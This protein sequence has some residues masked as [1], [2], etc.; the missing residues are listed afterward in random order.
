MKL[1]NNLQFIKKTTSDE[2]YNF[3][4]E[5]NKNNLVRRTLHKPKTIPKYNYTWKYNIK[6]KFYYCDNCDSI[7][8]QKYCK[9]CK[10]KLFSEKDFN[11]DDEISLNTVSTILENNSYISD[12]GFVVSNK[13]TYYCTNCNQYYYSEF[14][15]CVSKFE[16][17]FNQ[18]GYINNN[19][20][21]FTDNLS[22][23]L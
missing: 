6:I 16:Y 22:N 2:P 5:Y 23:Q 12:D 15:T 11:K 21:Y 10:R 3:H 8:K 18:N 4:V 14:H 19:K 13:K 7:Y 1:I 9:C 20:V 17:I